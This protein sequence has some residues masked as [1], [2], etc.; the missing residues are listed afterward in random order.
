MAE[1]SSSPL[2]RRTTVVHRLLRDLI[3][4]SSDLELNVSR[5]A[6]SCELTAEPTIHIAAKDVIQNRKGAR[7]MNAKRITPPSSMYSWMILPE[8]Q[9]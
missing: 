2:R 8:C 4:R 3:D 7:I 5:V 6:T 1:L 9:L